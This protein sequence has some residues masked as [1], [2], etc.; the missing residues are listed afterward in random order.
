MNAKIINTDRIIKA[1][2]NNINSFGAV[3]NLS[4]SDKT[5]LIN[6]HVQ[7]GN[8]SEASQVLKTMDPNILKTYEQM[9]A[10][11]LKHTT[12]KTLRQ[13]RQDLAPA[14]RKN[15]KTQFNNITNEIN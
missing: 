3:S 7:N 11:G 2:E 14:V 5:Q 1:N 10:A 4:T 8:I 15:F 9:K 13:S 6:L 12:I